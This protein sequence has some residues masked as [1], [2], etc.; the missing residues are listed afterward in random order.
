MN[1]AKFKVRE[2]APDRLPDLLCAMPK[3]ELHMHIEEIGRA[4]C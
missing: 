3:A 4:S 1:S 2:V